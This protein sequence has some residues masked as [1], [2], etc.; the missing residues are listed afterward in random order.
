MR[1]LDQLRQRRGVDFDPGPELHV[2]HEF[3]RAFEE[4]TRVGKRGAMEEPDVD[5]RRERVDV[6]EGRSSSCREAIVF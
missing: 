1:D 2:S 4:T 6:R 5:V 3:P